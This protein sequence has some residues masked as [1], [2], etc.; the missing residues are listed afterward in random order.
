MQPAHI[1]DQD[2]GLHHRTCTTHYLIDKSNVMR[3]ANLDISY[4]HS[5]KARARYS[6]VSP[7]LH[8]AGS[9]THPAFSYWSI[10]SIFQVQYNVIGL[11]VSQLVRD[12]LTLGITSRI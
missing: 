1:M 10:S 3:M 11:R 12:I 6:A 4:V 8:A 9:L 7:T 5:S 2:H